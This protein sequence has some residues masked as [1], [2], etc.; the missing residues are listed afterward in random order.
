MIIMFVLVTVTALRLPLLLCLF[1]LFLLFSTVA[2]LVLTIVL[3]RVVLDIHCVLHR[4]WTDITCEVCVMYFI[5][6]CI[7]YTYIILSYL[8]ISRYIYI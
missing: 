1:T 2:M 4:P 6:I 5:P 7:Y 8:S 3:S